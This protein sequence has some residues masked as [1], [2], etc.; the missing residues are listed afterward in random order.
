MIGKTARWLAGAILSLGLVPGFVSASLESGSVTFE[1]LDTPPLYFKA[2]VNYEVFAPGDATSPSPSATDFTYV[3]SLANQAVAPPAGQVN[4]P[5][6]RLDVG[7]GSSANITAA[8]STGAGVAPSAIDTSIATKVQ[9]IFL[10]PFVNPGQSSNQLI[11]HSPNGPGDVTATVAFGGSN[12]DQLLRGPFSLPQKDFACFGLNKVKIL[13]K[14]NKTGADQ[15]KLE[16]GGLSFAAGDSFDP[17][18]D[19]VKLDL[20]SGAYTLSIPAG[21]F[22]RKGAR[23]DFKYATGSGVTPE[24]RFRINVDKGEWSLRVNKTDVS[25][26]IDATSLDVTLMIGDV[27]GMDT[28]PLTV[29][30]DNNKVKHLHFFRKPRLE[31]PKLRE[32]DS[33]AANDTGSGHGHHRRSCLS[34]FEVTYHLGQ[35]DQEII[36]QFEGQIGHPDTTVSITAGSSATFHTSCSACLQCGQTDASGDFTITGISDATG[37]MTSSCGGVDPSC[38][39]TPAAPGDTGWACVEHSDCNS[40]SCALGLCE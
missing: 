11:I 8:S 12:D 13:Q 3:Y 9:F 5:L 18:T 23:E 6:D 1:N 27:K 33:S 40:G 16:K 17:T 20:N 34:S 35:S 37:K 39:Q 32:D 22:E 15:I 4:I 24:V 21:S 10:S 29:V 30:Q 19:I 28:I 2:T 26:L 36:E 7:V 25:T 14:K 38:D 31:C